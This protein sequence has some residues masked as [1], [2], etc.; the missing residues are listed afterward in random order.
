MPLRLYFDAD[1]GV[2][3][4]IHDVQFSKGKQRP[5]PLGDPSAHFRLFVPQDRTRPRRSHRFAPNASHTITDADLEQQF[6][7]AQYLA[8]QKFD[9]NRLTPGSR[10]EG[11][12]RLRKR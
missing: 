6:R 12:T 2:A 11:V 8:T 7:Q 9:T 1:D 5:V 10:P 3:Y 4:R